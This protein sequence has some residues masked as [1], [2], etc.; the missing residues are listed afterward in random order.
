MIISYKEISE[1]VVY[2]IPKEKLFIDW[3]IFISAFFGALIAGLF[4]YIGQLQGGKKLLEY[5][6]LK[7][8]EKEQK[9][10]EYLKCNAP[11]IIKFI[12]NKIINSVYMGFIVS[13][14]LHTKQNIDG[15]YYAPFCLKNYL[16]IKKQCEYLVGG[17]L[18]I[19]K[20]HKTAFGPCFPYKL[21]NRLTDL[22]KKY[23]N[24]K[25]EAVK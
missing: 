14:F 18:L 21:T 17:N 24:N 8:E 12:K 11:A 23:E 10:Y 1:L 20:I 19:P 3:N 16:E 15:D 9:D 4:S 13:N 25:K 2:I 7:E 22:I 5:Q 6:K